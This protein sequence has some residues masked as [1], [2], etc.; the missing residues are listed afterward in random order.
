MTKYYFYYYW[1][2]GLVYC[3]KVAETNGRAV[4]GD[5]QAIP[6][7]KFEI[8]EHEWMNATL[9]DLK[10]RYEYQDTEKNNG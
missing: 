1:C 2:F 8:T 9:F 6:G 4:G 10:G 3:G 7:N 5:I